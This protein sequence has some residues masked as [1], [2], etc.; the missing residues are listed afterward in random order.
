[1]YGKQIVKIDL[2]QMPVELTKLIDTKKYLR[3]LEEEQRLAKDDIKKL[4]EQIYA[5]EGSYLE[6]TRNG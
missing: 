2:F 1:M 5:F 4:E 3:Q 6:D